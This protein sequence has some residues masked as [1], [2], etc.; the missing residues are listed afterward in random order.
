MRGDTP[1]SDSARR[2]VNI[3]ELSR[4]ISLSIEGKTEEALEQLADFL[5]HRPDSTEA[6]WVRGQ[7]EFELGRFE[8][9]RVSYAE[10]VARR[11]PEHW[12]AY[13]NRGLCLDKL[14][15]LEEA[16]GDFRKAA[17]MCPERPET[18]VALGACLLRRRRPEE[19]IEAFD[20]CLRPNPAEDRALFGK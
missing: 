16:T 17:G 1:K 3:E 11:Q 5:K 10:V 2:K 12:A 9:A 15:E 14:E 19:A 7:I 8:Q 20:N 18:H 4:A 6:W 13:F